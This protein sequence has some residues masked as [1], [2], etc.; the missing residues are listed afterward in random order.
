MLQEAYILL[1]SSIL[2]IIMAKC[3]ERAI[4]SSQ[5]VLALLFAFA[6]VP[7]IISQ[8]RLRYS[9][10]LKSL[11]MYADSCEKFQRTYFCWNVTHSCPPRRVVFC[12]GKS[13]IEYFRISQ[14]LQRC[15]KLFQTV[16]KEFNF[17]NYISLPS[18]CYYIP[19]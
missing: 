6:L 10:I 19:P 11:Q 17:R 9:W 2:S 4:S 12:S 13:W 16:F 5:L 15:S 18:L 8:Y 3:H 7:C 14:K 1:T